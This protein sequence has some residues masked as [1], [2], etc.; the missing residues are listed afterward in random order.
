M[1]LATLQDKFPTMG[2]HSGT[3]SER[4][5]PLPQWDLISLSQSCS[6]PAGA[7][8]PVSAKEKQSYVIG[9]IA[10]GGKDMGHANGSFRP[11]LLHE[12]PEHHQQQVSELI[13]TAELVG[14]GSPAE[15]ESGL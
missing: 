2:K 9:A 10:L 8:L 11:W 7:K 1:V 6:H 5:S 15:S 13:R 3:V 4:C 12:I 14:T